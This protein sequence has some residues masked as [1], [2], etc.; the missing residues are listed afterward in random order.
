MS[1]V[2]YTYQAENLCPSCTLKV[3]RASG[4]TVQRGKA[5]ED[6]IRRAAQ[7]LNIDFD[8]QHAYDSGDF[9]RPITKQQCETELTEVPDSKPGVRHAISDERCTGA[10]CGKWLVLGEKSP[11]E[12][13]LIRW[14]RDEYELPQALARAIARKLREWGL[15]HPEFITEDNIRE[16]AVMSP[17]DYATVHADI[18]HERAVNHALVRTPQCDGDPCFY[19]EQPWEKHVFTC[20]TCGIDVP[21]DAAHAHQEQVKGQLKFSQARPTT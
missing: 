14:V 7:K 10:K 8:D 13:G 4:I 3:M 18:G 12:A 6:A 16:A 17:H 19:C 1:V 21:A 9:P 20:E 15:S 2:G 11:T 5:H